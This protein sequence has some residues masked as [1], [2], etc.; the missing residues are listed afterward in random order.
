MNAFLCSFSILV[1]VPKTFKKFRL[2][3]SFENFDVGSIWKT[4]VT[5]RYEI[6]R[7]LAIDGE[8]SQWARAAPQEDEDQFLLGGRGTLR[9]KK[10]T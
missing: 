6:L 2:K 3:N 8:A 9:P 5:I 10:D 1:N 7:D 4:F